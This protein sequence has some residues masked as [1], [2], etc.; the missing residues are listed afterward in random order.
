MNLQ[1]SASQHRGTGKRRL[2]DCAYVLAI[3]GLEPP[4]ERG[5]TCQH[6]S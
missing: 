6:L 1:S 4:I 2:G 3:S 5:V